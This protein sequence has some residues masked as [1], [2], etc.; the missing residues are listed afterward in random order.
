MKHFLLGFMLLISLATFGQTQYDDFLSLNE[1]W[2]IAVHTNK[3]NKIKAD[4]NTQS[5]LLAI[6]MLYLLRNPPL[7]T[8][9][10]HVLREKT[11]EDFGTNFNEWYAWWWKKEVVMD[12]GYMNFKAHL[13]TFID[14]HFEAYFLDRQDQILIEPSEI[15]WGGVVQDG[16]PPLRQPKMISASEASYLDDSN[17]VFG[18]AINGD[19][20]AYP[21]RI[22][23]WHEMFVDEIGGV[24]IAGVYCTLCGTVIAYDAQDFSLGT[25]GFL[26]RSNKLMYDQNTQSLWSTLD[27]KPVVGPLINQGIV[28]DYHPIVTTTWGAWKAA[29]PDTKVL[30]I[31]TGLQRNYGEGVA[32]AAYFATDELMFAVRNVDKSLANKEEVLVIKKNGFSVAMHTKYLNRNKVAYETVNGQEFVI[33]TDK[34]GANRVYEIKGQPIVKYKKGVVTD[35]DDHRWEMTEDELSHHGVSYNRYPAFRAFW[36][37]WYGANPDTRLVK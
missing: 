20:R 13:H 15:R 4:W 19:V 28:L 11:G 12:A 33:L 27:G 8:R 7:S 6:E 2:P 35:T 37:G 10:L 14:E 34:S 16:I 32:Y 22:L 21:K 17:V 36:F 31:E 24:N 5:P 18:L 30:A 1:N 26:Y 3:V 25:S 9:L 29:H 23:A